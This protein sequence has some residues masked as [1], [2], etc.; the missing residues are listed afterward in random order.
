M[1]DDLTPDEAMEL[2]RQQEAMIK[3]HLLKLVFNLDVGPEAFD[4]MSDDLHSQGIIR[5]PC[6]E[7]A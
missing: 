7:C 3:L 5:R 1:S 2:V 4:V 6:C